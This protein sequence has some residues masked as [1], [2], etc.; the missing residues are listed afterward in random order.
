MLAAFLAGRLTGGSGQSGSA[1]ETAETAQEPVV[2][3]CSMHPQILQP[4]P[5][6]CPICAMDLIPLT[7]DASSNEGPRTLVLSEAAAALAEIQTS[8]VYRSFPEV[9]VPLVGQLDFDETRMRSLTARFPAR[10]EQLF[11]NFTGVPV[12]AGE[13]LALVYSPEL[14]VA[15][16]EFILAEQENPGGPLAQAARRKLLQW[17]LLPWQ[18]DAI[19]ERGQPSDRFELMAPIGGVVIEKHVN[20]GDYVETGEP[21]FKIADLSRLWLMLD[22][23]ASD[24]PWLH[25]GQQVEFTVEAWPGETFTGIIAFIAP[26]LNRATRTV[27]LRVNV[28]NPDGRLKPGMFARA[29]VKARIAAEGKVY[30]PELAGKW[31]SPMHPEIIKDGP[32]SCDVCGMD[33][34]PIETLG[35]TSEP[36]QEAPLLVPAQAVLRTGERAVVYRRLPDRE[37]PTFEGLEIVLGPRAG[38]AFVVRS[39][40]REG[41][42]VVTSG[43]FKIDSALQ[44]QARPSMMSVPDGTAP[45][46]EKPLQIETALASASIGGYFKLQ[47][48]LAADDLETARA[49]LMGIMQHSGHEGDLADL[50][51]RMLAAEDLDA[52]RRPD[53]EKLSLAYIAAVKAAPEAFSGPIYLMS[54]PM[55]YDDRDDPAAPWLQNQEELLNPYFGAMMLYC[56]EELGKLR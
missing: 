9:E 14:S 12:G 27:R 21:L 25:Y 22:A 45:V 18:A 24:L 3:T 15:Q 8:E 5:G 16:Y 33:L 36:T 37:A 29:T 34:V 19:L 17:D 10:M 35:Y 43:A 52:M 40:L 7:D 13:H 54:C 49:G 39:G 51:H 41:D 1:P 20:E 11:V 42:R 47:A 30:A 56:G 31:I 32:G 48:G 46:A 53:F 44:I 50:V 26:E 6:L 55:V 28:E 38:D 23:Y 4:D 2:W